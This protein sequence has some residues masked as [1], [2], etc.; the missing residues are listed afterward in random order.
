MRELIE[1]KV[2][3]K[4]GLRKLEMRRGEVRKVRKYEN[5]GKIIRQVKEIR[6]EKMNDRGNL[7]SYHKIAEE[8]YSFLLKEEMSAFST[9]HSS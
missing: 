8:Q 2:A 7:S 4:C 1:R 9:V 5:R 6:L 3:G